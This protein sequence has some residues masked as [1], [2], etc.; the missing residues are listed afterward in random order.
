[1]HLR[2][3]DTVVL[4]GTATQA[5]LGDSKGFAWLWLAQ[6]SEAELS[7]RHRETPGK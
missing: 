2:G 3:G 4:W 6:L 7:S 1:M 5:C